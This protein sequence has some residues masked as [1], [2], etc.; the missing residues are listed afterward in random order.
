MINKS[1]ESFTIPD[2]DDT[3]DVDAPVQALLVFR[4]PQQQAIKA[5]SAL[6]ARVTGQSV[7][8]L[9]GS[10]TLRS[11]TLRKLLLGPILAEPLMVMSA[12][13][14]SLESLRRARCS[15]FWSCHGHAHIRKSVCSIREYEQR[16]RD[17]HSY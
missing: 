1:I 12:T 11:L 17:G 8:Q 5:H 9:S 15:C 14:D 3:F 7:M 16:M 13:N 10:K 2:V 6:S 4:N